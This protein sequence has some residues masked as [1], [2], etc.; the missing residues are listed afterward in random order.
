MFCLKLLKPLFLYQIISSFYETLTIIIIF[1]SLNWDFMQKYKLKTF[2]LSF[3]LFFSV[4]ISQQSGANEEYSNFGIVLSGPSGAGKSTIIKD[5]MKKHKNVVMSVSATTRQNR[6]GEV[7]GVDYFF[8]AKDQF[9][10]LIDKGEFLEYVFNFDNYYGTPKRNY[11]DAV[12]NGKDIIFDTTIGGMLKIK[13]NKNTDIVSVFIEPPS[14]KV[15]EQR[16]RNRK[17]ETASSLKKRLESAKKE[18]QY[19]GEYDYIIY[20]CDEA[21]SVKQFETIYNAEKYKRLLKK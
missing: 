19:A 6:N 12:M 3:I 9:K 16:L 13:N 20:N 2:T 11:I 15:L 1:F 5:F 7:H 8:I 17:T 21:D 10:N 4:A 14:M 18:T